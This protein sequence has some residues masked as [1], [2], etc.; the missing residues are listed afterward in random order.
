MTDICRKQCR[1]TRRE[2]LFNVACLARRTL[3]VHFRRG[4]TPTIRRQIILPRLP[5][6]YSPF[7]KRY[8]GGSENFTNVGSSPQAIKII[9]NHVEYY[10]LLTF[11]K[12]S[13]GFGEGSSHP[14]SCKIIYIYM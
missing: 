2:S 14:R 6:V 10:L 1:K 4:I 8:L 5:L 12:Y 9:L 3:H 11:L 13:N 7:F